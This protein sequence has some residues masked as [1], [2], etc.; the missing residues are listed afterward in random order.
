MFQSLLLRK[1]TKMKISVWWQHFLCCC[2]SCF[3]ILT[4]LTAILFAFLKH[5]LRILHFGDRHCCLWSTFTGVLKDYL[6]ELPSPLITKQL[7]EAV[8]DAMVKSPLKMSS[9][10][11]ENESS[12]S[13]FAVG[14]LNCLPDVEKVSVLGRH[15]PWKLAHE[16]TVHARHYTWS[17]GLWHLWHLGLGPA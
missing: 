17:L 8:L 12:D 4:K 13:Q 1:L 3:Q 10:G 2:L 7:Y 15:F 16:V 6:R 14:L 5:S 11:C 9:N